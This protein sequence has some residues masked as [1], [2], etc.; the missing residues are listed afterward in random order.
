MPL[1]PEQL[2]RR[3]RTNTVIVRIFSLP[4]F[5]LSVLLLVLGLWAMALVLLSV[6]FCMTM[7]LLHDHD[8]VA[9]LGAV[10]APAWPTPGERRLETA[11][12]RRRERGLHYHR[13][14]LRV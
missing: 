12:L 1:T 13:P 4:F 8:V 10:I 3:W 7:R 9:T 2:E 11:S 6:G 14:A 5:V